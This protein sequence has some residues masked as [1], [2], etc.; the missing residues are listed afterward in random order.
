M[1]PTLYQTDLRITNHRRRKSPP[2]F[3]LLSSVQNSNQMAS[4]LTTN[5]SFPRI[6]FQLLQFSKQRPSFSA[7]KAA[8]MVKTDII[9]LAFSSRFVD[10]AVQF[11]FRCKVFIPR[12]AT[13]ESGLTVAWF[14]STNHKFLLRIVTNEIAIWPAL[15]FYRD[16]INSLRNGR[17]SD[18]KQIENAFKDPEVGFW[19]KN[20]SQGIVGNSEV[21]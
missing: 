12:E 4:R 10:F 17:D 9:F 7:H 2:S 20:S 8:L 14:S 21:Y 19:E 3:T 16:Q 6:F 13:L 11:C 18:L 5:T 1:S 15:R